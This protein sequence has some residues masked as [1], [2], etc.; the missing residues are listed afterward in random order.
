[1]YIEERAVPQTKTTKIGALKR[2][3]HL[4]VMNRF[5]DAH[6]QGRN[7]F[8][9]NYLFKLYTMWLVNWLVADLQCHRLWGVRINDTERQNGV[10]YRHTSHVSETVDYS[11]TLKAMG[12]MGHKKGPEFC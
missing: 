1:M 3:I 5:S 6:Q 12:I 7:P 9:Y 2:E 4:E 10:P 11:K 8:R